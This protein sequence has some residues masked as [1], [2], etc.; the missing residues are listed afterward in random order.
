M[1]AGLLQLG[2][3]VA[4]NRDSE[5][6]PYLDII[7]NPNEKEGYNHVLKITFEKGEELIYKGVAYEE[8]DFNKIGFLYY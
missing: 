2:D 3:Y 7:E 5:T 8:F 1:L 4:Q 6:N